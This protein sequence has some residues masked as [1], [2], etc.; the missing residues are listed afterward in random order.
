[1]GFKCHY[2]FD[3]HIAVAN[4]YVAVFNLRNTHVALSILRVQGHPTLFVTGIRDFFCVLAS[5]RRNELS[6]VMLSLELSATPLPIP[7]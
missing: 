2:L 3:P 7:K 6:R 1:M 5:E 4:V